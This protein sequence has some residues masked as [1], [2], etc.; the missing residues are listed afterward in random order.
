MGFKLATEHVPELIISDIIMPRMTGIE[1]CK[2][3]KEEIITSH[4]P[5]ILLTAKITLEDKIEGIETGADAYITKPFNIRHIEVT[6]KNLIDTRHKLFQ[7][8]SQEAYMMPKEISNN[9]LDQK[10]L[11]KIIGYIEANITNDELTVENLAYH[12]LMSRGHIWRKIKSLTGQTATEFIR[13]I[14]LKKSIKLI[15]AG[16]LNISEVAFKVGFASPAYY[17]KCFKAQFGTSPTEFLSNNPGK[18]KQ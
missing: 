12:L 6:I 3:I 14:R 1:L 5:F 7:R 15:E 2:K 10:F 4:I 18:K 11:E 13:T 17:T 16:E 8:F 9:E